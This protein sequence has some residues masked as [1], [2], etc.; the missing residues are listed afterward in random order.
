M[1]GQE[2]EQIHV[3][4]HSSFCCFRC[5]FHHCN[6]GYAVSL[7]LGFGLVSEKETYAAANPVHRRWIFGGRADFVA[8]PCVFRSLKST[9]RQLKRSPDFKAVFLSSECEVLSDIG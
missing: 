6:Q 8:D 7:R 5:G 4:F 9:K 2:T 1:T 3:G